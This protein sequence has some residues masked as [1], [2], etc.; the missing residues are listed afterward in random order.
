MGRTPRASGRTGERADERERVEGEGE[1][2]GG[3]SVE[4]SARTSVEASVEGAVPPA[5]S[6]SAAEGP[7]T[8]DRAADGLTPVPEAS[9]PPG[10]LLG[11]GAGIRAARLRDA[12]RALDR[13]E[14]RSVLDLMLSA[15]EG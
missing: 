14:I 10:G 3:A 13:G 11:A 12:R 4:A 1:P 6:P 15:L 7:R 9:A 8:G 5:P 2:A